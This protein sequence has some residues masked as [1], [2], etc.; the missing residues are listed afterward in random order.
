MNRGII[1]EAPTKAINCSWRMNIHNRFYVKVTDSRTN[2]VKQEARAFN[3]IC[4][5]LWT[6]LLGEYFNFI[7]YG[8]GKGTPAPSDT[9]LFSLIARDQVSSDSIEVDIPNGVC[10]NTKSITLD[11]T[12]SVGS[13][14]TEVGIYSKNSN[15]Y[16]CTHAMLEDMNGNPITITKTNTD[17]ITIYATV[18]AHWNPSGENGVYLMPPTGDYS[19]RNI[20]DAAIGRGYADYYS[21]Y[22]SVYN[23]ESFALKGLSKKGYQSSRHV[24]MTMNPESKVGSVSFSRFSV[25]DANVRGFGWVALS[26]RSSDSFGHEFFAVDVRGRYEIT[27]E[28]VGTGDGSTTVF[29]TQFE[30]PTE[31][32]VYVDGEPKLS[33]VTVNPHPISDD[34]F[35]YLIQ[36]RPELYNGNICPV[37]GWYG[38]YTDEYAYL[39]NPLWEL[40]IASLSATINYAKVAFSDDMT[41][42]SNEYSISTVPSAYRHSKYLRIRNTSTSNRFSLDVFS[43]TFPSQISS[44]NIV[45]DEAPDV[46]SVITV[47][48]ITPFVPKDENHVYDLNFTVQFG[49]PIG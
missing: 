13:E 36:I 9:D 42:W 34:V 23:S 8:S 18:F 28:S 32:V 20:L 10:S 25:D 16:L 38:G 44:K 31:A 3:V 15:S 48:Y 4:N 40:G 7:G 47:D 1:K 46:G 35:E 41:N 22:G 6:D 12:T 19:Y 24:P 30:F 39:Y 49:E 14:I 33:G 11:E 2:E 5:R 27:G 45:F 29:S 26:R 43:G 37:V 21:R 17:I